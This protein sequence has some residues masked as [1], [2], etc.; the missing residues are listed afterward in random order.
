VVVPG[1]L[2]K[3]PLHNRALWPSYGERA[4][5]FQVAGR[6]AL[7]TGERL[8]QVGRQAIDYFCAPARAFLSVEDRPSNVPVEKDH[9]R[10]GGQ[11]DAQSFL[12]DT[13]LDRGECSGILLR[14]R[15]LGRRNRETG[16]GPGAATSQPG[17]LLLTRRLTGHSQAPSRLC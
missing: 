7:H 3:R 13:Y 12:L 9:C 15:C 6:E 8:A 17:L 1:Y 10:I 4:H 2:C 5:V 14:K 16:F 11:D